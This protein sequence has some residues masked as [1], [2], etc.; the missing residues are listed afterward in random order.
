MDMKELPKFK[1][2][3]GFD[4]MDVEFEARLSPCSP[5]KGRDGKRN[6]Y[7]D[8]IMDEDIRCAK[9]LYIWLLPRSVDRQSWRFLHVGV[10]EK[11]CG[12]LTK[13]TMAHCRNAFG[14][15]P[16]HDYDMGNSGF[17]FLGGELREKT[18]EKVE[19]FLRDVRILFLIAPCDCKRLIRP[20][21]G[22]L[23]RCADDAYK[24]LYGNCADDASGKGCQ[25]TNTISKVA[26][27]DRDDMMAVR[28]ELN[29]VFEVLPGR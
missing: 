12:S 13:R 19:A 28:D 17:G 14:C 3:L 8:W 23:A 25:I 6:I 7:E 10:S 22:A 18:D 4:S 20:L 2:P 29:R 11:G 21:K 1:V 27:C 26:R 15:D 16:L 9:G 24:S 5:L